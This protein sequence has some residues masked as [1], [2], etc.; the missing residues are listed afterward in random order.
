M[1]PF[2]ES[3]L[4][5]P[6]PPSVADAT[7]D[8]LM[9]AEYAGRMKL[10]NA[11]IVG[12]LTRPD[13]YDPAEY[14]EDAAGAL[15]YLADQFETDADRVAEELRASDHLRGTATRAHDYRSADAENLRTREAVLR[16][17]VASLRAHRDDGGYLLELVE[18]A[19]EDAWA[20]ISRAVQESLDR[21]AIVV[22]ASYE[23]ER[24]ER[25][26]LLVAE[27]LAQ[28]TARLVAER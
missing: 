22:D 28:L 18:G 16:S 4:P 23:R 27:D 12:V 8:G 3:K 21:S 19:R 14:L 15:G 9:L 1:R 25:M 7:S 26:R 5:S 11:V 20:D 13:S 24:T 6:K 17:V 10:K 2:D